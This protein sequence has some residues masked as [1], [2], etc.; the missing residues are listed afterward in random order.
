MLLEYK[1]HYQHIKQLI[2]FNKYLF[3]TMCQVMSQATEIKGQNTR[4]LLRK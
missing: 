4:G 1:L 2:L 3:A